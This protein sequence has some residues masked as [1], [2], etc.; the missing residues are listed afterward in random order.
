MARW[1]ITECPLGRAKHDLREY[2][3][4][5]ILRQLRIPRRYST[6]GLLLPPDLPPAQVAVASRLGRERLRLR[7]ESPA[8]GRGV[9][10]DS[11]PVVAGQL[12][13]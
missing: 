11:R 12:Y 7:S 13:V 9:V 10:R 4:H 6:I 2:T 5:A 3:R 1:T 8:R